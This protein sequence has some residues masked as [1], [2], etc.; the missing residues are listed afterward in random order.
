[1][2]SPDHVGHLRRYWQLAREFFER[3]Y[4]GLAAFFAVTMI[5]EVGKLPMLAFQDTGDFYN[6]AK[7]Y[8]SAVGVT[9]YVNS[10]VSHIYGACESEFAKWY[11]TGELFKIRNQGLYAEI[12]EARVCLPDESVSP[13]KAF[14]IVCMA[15][16]VFA[17]IQGAYTGT[18]PE[19]W[20]EA[21]V[22]VDAFF[23]AHEELL[24]DCLPVR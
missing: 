21:L 19:E 6:H 11:R 2:I 22:E 1:M 13:R 15:G 12:V 24:R 3:G 14:L 5:E 7:K 20:Q 18:G 23:N 8:D 4:S 16:E 17:E 10:R 9:L